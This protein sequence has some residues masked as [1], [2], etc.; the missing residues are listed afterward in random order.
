M[1]HDFDG[2]GDECYGYIYSGTLI[3]INHPEVEEVKCIQ[4]MKRF[5]GLNVENV[6]HRLKSLNTWPPVSGA[7]CQVYGIFRRQRFAEG[8]VSHRRFCAGLVALLPCPTFFPLF[9]EYSTI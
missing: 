8:S 6:S 4:I 1:K 9:S 5:V 3:I 7:A 2:N